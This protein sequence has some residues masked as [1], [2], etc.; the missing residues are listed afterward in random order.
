M[1]IVLLAF[2]NIM[3]QY[4]TKK[5]SSRRFR[6]QLILWVVIL[7]VLVCSF[8]AYN[9]F[10]GKH[11]FDSSELSSFDIIQTTAIIYMI[12][13]INTHRQKIEHNEKFIRDLHQELSIKL[14]GKEPRF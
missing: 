8:P 14:S 6:R 9:Y 7:L 11:V 12:Y 2:I 10:S 3:T 1:P 5:I 4:K 13:I